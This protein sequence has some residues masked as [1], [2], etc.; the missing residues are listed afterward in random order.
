MKTEQKRNR[1]EE[2]REYN[3]KIAALGRIDIL[4]QITKDTQTAEKLREIRKEVAKIK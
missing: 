1:R 4:L 3:H 2:Q